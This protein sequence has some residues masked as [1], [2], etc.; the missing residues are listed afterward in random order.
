MTNYLLLQPLAVL[1]GVV[2]VVALLQGQDEWYKKL[3]SS[4]Q[5]LNRFQGRLR[6]AYSHYSCSR[7]CRWITEFLGEIGY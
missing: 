4:R 1:C 5:R 2:K 7:Y 3:S 6:C